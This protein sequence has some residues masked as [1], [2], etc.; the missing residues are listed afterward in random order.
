MAE[1]VDKVRDWAREHILAS[2]LIVAA[3]AAAGTWALTA[4]ANSSAY[5]SPH[6]DDVGPKTRKAAKAILTATFSLPT[7][8]NK[9]GVGDAILDLEESLAVK[10]EL[11]P[12]IVPFLEQAEPILRELRLAGGRRK[13][14]D[15]IT[16]EQK[17][18]V[19]KFMEMAPRLEGLFERLAV[20]Y[21]KD[22]TED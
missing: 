21:G 14:G 16:G 13:E 11:D 22:F 20:R 6:H 2:L 4:I 7:E 8:W 1:A 12:E 9:G 19:A 5:S 15:P 18:L 10:D 3:A 17:V